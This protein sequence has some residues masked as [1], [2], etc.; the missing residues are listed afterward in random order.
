MLLSTECLFNHSNS[1]PTANSWPQ[2]LHYDVCHSACPATRDKENQ[3]S[4]DR[5]IMIYKTIEIVYVRRSSILFSGICKQI[6]DFFLLYFFLRK[7]DPVGLTTL[8]EIIIKGMISF[9][10]NDVRKSRSRRKHMTKFLHLLPSGITLYICAK[11]S[12]FAGN[13]Q[14]KTWL[15]GNLLGSSWQV[16]S[17]KDILTDLF[18]QLLKKNENR[19][20]KTDVGEYS[21]PVFCSCLVPRT[22]W[23]VKISDL[24][25]FNATNIAQQKQREKSS[26]THISI[27]VTQL[28]SELHFHSS[29]RFSVHFWAWKQ[30]MTWAGSLNV[31]ENSAL[32]ATTLKLIWYWKECLV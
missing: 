32:K 20:L 3:R 30:Q 6:N 28:I 10:L 25:D 21:Q 16:I 17:I 13:C 15:K 12:Y 8:T 24:L 26:R 14:N 27:T 9:P 23:K 22:R 19:N 5:E 11:L 1:T 4:R 29:T 18:H 7:H 2:W 31:Q